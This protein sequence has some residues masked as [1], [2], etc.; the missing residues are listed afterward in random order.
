MEPDDRFEVLR[1]ALPQDLVTDAAIRALADQA[2]ELELPT[3][4][5]LVRD[6]QPA[7]ESWLVLRGRIEIR[8]RS[9]RRSVAVEGDFIDPTDCFA[10]EMPNDPAEEVATITARALES[11]A[12]LA[13]PS[14][15]AGRE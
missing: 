1:R 8:R 5:I 14:R 11:A 3:G 13:V 15:T 2:C 7:N 6:G 4:V 9:G 12:V 10:G